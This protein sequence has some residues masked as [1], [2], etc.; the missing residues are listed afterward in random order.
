MK[1]VEDALA[2][3]DSG[4][5]TGSVL[6]CEALRILAE[7]VSR[8]RAPRKPNALELADNLCAYVDQWNAH[9]EQ[10]GEDSRATLDAEQQMLEAREVLK[11]YDDFR[12]SKK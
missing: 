11:Q 8:L 2:F 7:E 10:Y 3:V 9:A 6:T 12:T 4:A 5:R 1:T